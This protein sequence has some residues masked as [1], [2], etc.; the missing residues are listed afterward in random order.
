MIW[1]R[2]QWHEA[3]RQLTST[4]LD[5]KTTKSCATS[6]IRPSGTCLLYPAPIAFAPHHRYPGLESHPGHE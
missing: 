1:P 3:W 6:P 5:V 4:T 2:K